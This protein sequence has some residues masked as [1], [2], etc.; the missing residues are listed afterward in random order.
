MPLAWRVR[1]AC[2]LT[3][4]SGPALQRAGAVGARADPAA[5]AEADKQAR[6]PAAGGV[7]VGGF[8]LEVLGRRAPGLTSIL[9]QL[10]DR[11]RSQVVQQGR[12][13]ARF[14]RLWRIRLS[15]ALARPFEDGPM[16]FH[17][18]HLPVLSEMQQRLLDPDVISFNAAIS[19]CEKGEQWQQALGMLSEMQQRQREPSV[20]SFSAAI[21]TCEKCEQW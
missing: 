12:A 10:A 7:S 8:A 11:A 16:S 3:S 18:M 13:P 5:S 1:T 19:A 14:L 6:Y 20:I 15:A 9:T 17:S 2:W 4:L 21:S